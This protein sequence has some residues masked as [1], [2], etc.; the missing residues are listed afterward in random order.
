MKSDFKIN[1]KTATE[2]EVL[3]F[4][5]TAKEKDDCDLVSFQDGELQIEIQWFF[6]Q[7]WQIIRNF[8]NGGSCS[9]ICKYTTDGIIQWWNTK[10][11]SPGWADE[12]QWEELMISTSR[13]YKRLTVLFCIGILLFSGLGVLSGK[14]PLTA[15]L[16]IIAILM[17]VFI[18]MKMRGGGK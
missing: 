17:I 7:G 8:P 13:L 2:A 14:L 4:L 11:D 9:T 5:G 15:F 3:A 1:A 18:V 16:I 10:S 12:E 6:G